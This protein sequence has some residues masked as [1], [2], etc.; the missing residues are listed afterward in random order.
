M[1]NR[2]ALGLPISPPLACDRVS[3]LVMPTMVVRGDSSP[4]F[5]DAVMEALIACLP[6]SS[7]TVTISNASHAMFLDNP[8]AFNAAVLQFIQDN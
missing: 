6:A 3:S 2:M 8:A 5:V 7:T 1:D 4:A